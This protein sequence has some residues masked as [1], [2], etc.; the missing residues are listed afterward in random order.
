MLPNFK[1]YFWNEKNFSVGKDPYIALAYKTGNYAFVSDAVRL[2][3]L[4]KFG[5]IYLDLDIELLKPLTPLLDHT[6]FL[7]F[8]SKNHTSDWVNNA[9][10]GSIAQHQFLLDVRNQAV[11][12]F[13][14]QGRFIRSPEATTDVLLKYGLKN[15]GKQTVNSVTVFEKEAFYPVSYK[16]NYHQNLITDRSFCI[17]HWQGSWL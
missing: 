2:N 16:Q 7:G 13:I 1:F 3:T 14:K 5:G 11:S 6:C 15:Y 12:E 4:Y 17:H 10:L 9:I 8:Q